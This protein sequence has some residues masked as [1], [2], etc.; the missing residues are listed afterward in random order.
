MDLIPEILGKDGE[1][2]TYVCECTYW[3]DDERH[4]LGNMLFQTRSAISTK[5]LEESTRKVAG[6][7]KFIITDIYE[8]GG[9]K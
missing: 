6:A 3:K 8:S 5:E 9:F 7:D 1:L 2:I 4:T